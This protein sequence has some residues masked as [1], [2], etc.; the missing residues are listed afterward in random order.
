MDYYTFYDL[1]LSNINVTSGSV[2]TVW[3]ALLP[4]SSI[5]DKSLDVKLYGVK[6]FAKTSIS[7]SNEFKAGCAYSYSCAPAIVEG[8]E[9]VD[10]GLSANWAAW[11]LGATKP[12]EYGGYYQWA[13][14]EDVTSTS[15]NLGWSNC[16]YHTGSSALYGWTK[17]VP[18][19]KSSYWSG[20]GN[21]DNKTIL[22]TEDDVVQV[23]LG[24]NWRMPN[25]ALWNEL[26][27]NCTWEWTWDYNGTQVKGY[28][29]TSNEPGYIDKSIFLP[30]AGYRDGGSL[31]DVGSSGFYW[32][33]ALEGY[34]Y[35]AYNEGFYYGGRFSG[36]GYRY[37]GL[38]V[39]PVWLRM[40]THKH[41]LT[42]INGQTPT[43]TSSGWKDYYQCTDP[44]CG[45]YFED[46]DRFSSL[47]GDEY[48]LAAW[49]SVGGRGYLAP[50]TEIVDLGLSVKWRTCNLGATKP[51]EY[52]GHYQWAGTKDVTDKNIYLDCSNCPYHTGS[53]EYY[54]WTKY[55]PSGQSSYWSGTGSPDNKTTLDLEDDVAHVTLGGDWRMP[56]Y[57]EWTELRNNCTW[58]WTND[59]NGTGIKGQIVTSNKSGYT[60]KSIFL[61]VAGFRD[62]DDLYGSYGYGYYWSSSLPTDYPYYAYYVRFYSVGVDT[63]YSCRYYGLSV[64]PVQE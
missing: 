48:A 53:S 41:S 27:Y 1:K 42:K 21:P 31:Y 36:L 12:E 45:L 37:Y 40:S 64:R 34:P 22:E 29:V 30:A 16:P 57:D 50:I 20:A 55:I 60:D 2:L 24:D 44:V 8:P 28:V 18:S 46:A 61:P 4:T 63:N 11:N 51:E 52:G 33:S 13:G 38:S 32:S 39:R 10:L 62:D 5:K 35:S 43:F 58:E 17:Y 49:K 25:K 47:I 7:I 6:T 54:G 23:T 56:T 14:L 15:I 26:R 19:G 3:L 9:Y 59:Y